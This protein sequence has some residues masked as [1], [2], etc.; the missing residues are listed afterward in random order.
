MLK[1]MGDDSSSEASKDNQSCPKPW[2]DSTTVNSLHGFETK[3][4]R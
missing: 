1:S 2:I 4:I 3:Y